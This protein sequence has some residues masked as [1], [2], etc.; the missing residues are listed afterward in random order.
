[1]LEQGIFVLELLRNSRRWAA[2]KYDNG[3]VGWTVCKA[4][5]PVGIPVGGDNTNCLKLISKC[6]RTADP[7]EMVL[8]LT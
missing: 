8:E 6:T 2:A 1:M 5:N 3:M 4:G 7:A